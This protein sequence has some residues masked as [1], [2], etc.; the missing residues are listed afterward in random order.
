M[1][2]KCQFFLWPESK[3]PVA[4]D[5]FGSEISSD[6]IES[7]LRDEYPGTD[8]VLFSSA[9]AGMTAALIQLGLKRP[10]LVWTPRFS[11]HCVLEAI[12]HVATPSPSA[13]EIN[14]AALIYHQWG[15]V[16][17][18]EF[19]KDTVLIEDAV[20]N[21]LSPG[22]SPFAAGGQ[23]LLWSLPKVLGTSGGGVVF[24]R[25]GRDAEALRRIRKGRPASIIQAYLRLR[26]KNNLRA[27]LYWNGAEAMQGEL[28]APFRR[29][30]YRRLRE[31]RGVVDSRRELLRALSP[32][33]AAKFQNWHRLPSNLPLKPTPDVAPYWESGGVFSAGLRSFNTAGIFPESK[34]VYCAPLPVHMDIQL[35]DLPSV[36]TADGV[37]DRLIAMGDTPPANIK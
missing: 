1:T 2:A 30:A 29:Q 4:S 36:F 18:P 25:D 32:L 16:G 5:L 24:C 7:L 27:S 21:L 22:H 33:L 35:A 31:I 12:A 3:S 11:S 9:R 28:V 26:S 19:P 13:A 6:T 20:D 15:F 14:S 10:D 8:A 17:Q 23:F 37:E 34:W